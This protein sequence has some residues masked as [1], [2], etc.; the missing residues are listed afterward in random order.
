MGSSHP[1]QAAVDSKNS[2]SNAPSTTECRIPFGRKASTKP[3]P[4]KDKFLEEYTR[5]WT[6]DANISPRG[7]D[8]TPYMVRD[9]VKAGMYTDDGINGHSNVTRPPPPPRIHSLSEL[10][11]PA[12]VEMDSH[13]RSPSGNLLAPEQFLTHPSRPRSMRERQAEI[14]DKVRAASRLGTEMEMGEEEQKKKEKWY[15]RR[16]LFKD[17]NCF[18]I[19]F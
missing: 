8:H 6:I 9:M 14:R 12:E 7:T 16:V 18:D 1:K 5:R 13:I 15:S 11:D 10:I 17:C 4:S 19:C 3:P 2:T